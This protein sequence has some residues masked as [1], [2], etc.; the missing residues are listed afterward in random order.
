M[1]RKINILQIGPMALGHSFDGSRFRKLLETHNVKSHKTRRS[2]A[3]VLEDYT[4]GTRKR[5][6]QDLNDLSKK[7]S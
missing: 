4:F 6:A 3:Q 1:E 2:F 5:I 7:H